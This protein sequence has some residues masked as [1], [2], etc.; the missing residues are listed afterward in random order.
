[1][2]EYVSIFILLI[3]VVAAVGLVIYLYNTKWNKSITPPVAIDMTGI[4]SAYK[5]NNSYLINLRISKR[6][7][8]PVIGICRIDL[9]YLSGD[10]TKSAQLDL[11]QSPTSYKRSIQFTDGYVAI[12]NPVIRDSIEENMLVV[13]NNPNDRLLSVIFYLCI[14]GETTNPKWSETLSIPSTPLTP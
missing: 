14:Y 10:Q 11:A 5:I 2:N 9:S 1:M 6:S 13:F 4:T 8:S 7:D 3:L 12:D